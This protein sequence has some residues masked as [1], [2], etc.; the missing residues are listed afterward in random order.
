MKPT[1]KPYYLHLFVCTDPKPGGCGERGGEEVRKRLKEELDARG[2]GMEVR[3]SRCGSIGLCKFG[4]AMVAYPE[5]AWYV[6]VQP[7]DIPE[8]VEQH[9][10]HGRPV[11]RLL[12]HSLQTSHK[13]PVE[14]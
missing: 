1:M 10:I 8:I 9:V 12:V 7:G 3:V 13:L 4:P 2:I 5:G 14:V 11:E 6:H